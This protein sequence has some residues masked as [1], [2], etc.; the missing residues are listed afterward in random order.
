MKNF[1]NSSVLVTGGSGAVGTNLVNKLL[2]LGAKVTVLDN[3]SQSSKNNLQKSK[4]L[5]IINGDITKK[6]VL[7]KVFS[8]KFDYVFHLAA[9]F[10]NELSVENPSEDLHVNIEGTL[11]ILLFSSKQK[12]KRFVYSSSSSLY[13]NQNKVINEETKPYPS[14]PYAVSKLTGEYYCQAIQKLYG[15][16][17]TIVRLSNS[18]GPFDPAGQYRNV[19]PNFFKNAL[20]NKPIVITGTGKETRDFTYVEDTVNGILLAA[21]SKNGKNQTFNLGTGKETSIKKLAQTITEITNSKSKILFKP[22]RNFDHIKKRKM[23]IN[24]AKKL[25]GYNPQIDIKEGL[26]RTYQWLNEN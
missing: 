14:T 7:E 9:R 21:I 20:K 18:Y 15:L 12:L 3:F 24:K 13:G 6:A 2:E 23:N 17:Y 1:K 5:K 4:K 8:D 11:L 26:K 22:Q 25:I 19:I 10:A 16:E